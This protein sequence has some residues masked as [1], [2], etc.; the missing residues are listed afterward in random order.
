VVGIDADFPHD[1]GSLG[2]ALRIEAGARLQ[3]NMLAAVVPA[4]AQNL[5]PFPVRRS[6]VVLRCVWRA[7][8][9]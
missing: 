7:Y 4:Y 6:A 2:I 3:V 5:H 1:Y 9:C 8:H